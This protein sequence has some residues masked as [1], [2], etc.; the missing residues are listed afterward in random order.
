MNEWMKEESPRSNNSKASPESVQSLGSVQCNVN[1]LKSPISRVIKG[2]KEDHLARSVLTL[3]E[4]RHGIM[5]DIGMGRRS[6]L[7]H[8]VC[9]WRTCL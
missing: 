4:E 2:V 8:I 1:V 9:H 3:A 6:T 7:G 5:Q